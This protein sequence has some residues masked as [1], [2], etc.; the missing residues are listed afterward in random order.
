M[1]SQTSVR[2]ALAVF[3]LV[4]LQLIL[5]ALMRH[6]ES[7]LAIPDFPTTAGRLLPWFGEETLGW[8][9]AWRAD[10]SID[11]EQHLEAVSMG[12]VLIHFAHRV[13]AALVT[14]AVLLFATI[15]FR[16]RESMHA[17]W[18]LAHAMTI[19]LLVQLVLGA[20]TIWT[21][22]VP[23]IAS[24]HVAVGA[25]LLGLSTLA[26]LGAFPFR[27]PEPDT[28]GTEAASLSA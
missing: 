16:H 22:K 17:Q 18:R 19:C 28:A 10:Y 7:G 14:G 11:H 23:I 5:G 4:Y 9:N 25:A 27:A 21:Q 3:G 12:Q 6:T 26:V 20:S 24:L 1:A 2:P 8:I 15:M 13:G